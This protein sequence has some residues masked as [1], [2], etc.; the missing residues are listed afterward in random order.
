LNFS[1]CSSDQIEEGIARIGR[2]IKK[3]CS[4]QKELRLIEK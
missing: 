3:L 2:S 1:H 4:S